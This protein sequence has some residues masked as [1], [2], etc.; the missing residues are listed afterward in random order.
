MQYTLV[1]PLKYMMAIAVHLSSNAVCPSEAPEAHDGYCS[2]LEAP[3]VH[4]GLCSTLDVKRSTP[5]RL[6]K[7][8]KASYSIDGLCCTL[9]D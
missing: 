7:Y 6:L 9:N 3:E 8:L 5:V 2:T 1:R 4:D